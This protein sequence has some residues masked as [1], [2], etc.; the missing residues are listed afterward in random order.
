MSTARVDNP[1]LPCRMSND[2]LFTVERKF[3]LLV[4]SVKKF[5][6]RFH[7]DTSASRFLFDNSIAADAAAVCHQLLPRLVVFEPIFLCRFRVSGNR[8]GDVV[9]ASVLNFTSSSVQETH[10]YISR[11]PF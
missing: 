11:D 8:C 4:F 5:F 1:L 3:P 7:V 10:A 6:P 2:P 9:T